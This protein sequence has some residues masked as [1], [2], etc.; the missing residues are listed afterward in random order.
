M[1]NVS[2]TLVLGVAA[3][4]VLH[5]QMSPGMIFAISIIAGK[6]TQPMQTVVAQW[7]TI[8]ARPAIT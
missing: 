6:A 7:K 8:G 1:R 4:L 2:Q 5:N 3:Y